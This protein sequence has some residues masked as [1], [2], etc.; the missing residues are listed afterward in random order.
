MSGKSFLHIQKLIIDK[1]DEN[2]A[3]SKAD[4]DSAGSSGLEYGY[5]GVTGKELQIWRWEH[6]KCKKG[7]GK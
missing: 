3:V 1:D 5:K 6:E 4:R 7:E 2:A